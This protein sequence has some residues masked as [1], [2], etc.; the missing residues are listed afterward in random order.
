MIG[1]VYMT[2]RVLC[3]LDTQI[4]QM[5]AHAWRSLGAAYRGVESSAIAAA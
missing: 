3:V 5:C 1:S 2:P 4:G